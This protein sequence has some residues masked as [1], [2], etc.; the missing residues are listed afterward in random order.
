MEYLTAEIFQMNVYAP[1]I[2][3]W[4]TAQKKYAE[5]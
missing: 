1:L 3:L 4:K 2:S 5:D